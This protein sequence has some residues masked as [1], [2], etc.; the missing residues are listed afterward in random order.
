MSEPWR[1]NVF[2][3]MVS[4]VAYDPAKQE[5]MVTWAKSGKVSVY[6]GVPEGT[7]LDLS[8]AP[9]VGFFINSE[10]KPYFGH[11]YQ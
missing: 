3:S 1:K 4:E 8:N 7:A 10:I 2:S 9:S 6:S 11:R 5:L